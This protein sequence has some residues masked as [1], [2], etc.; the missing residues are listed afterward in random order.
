MN[1]RQP[2]TRH[3]TRGARYAATGMPTHARRRVRIAYALHAAVYTLTFTRAPHATPAHARPVGAPLAPLPT[4]RSARFL[5]QLPTSVGPFTGCGRL[6]GVVCIQVC[7]VYP[8]AP[9]L[10]T[11]Q[12][13]AATRY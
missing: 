7:V 1:D 5:D 13:A 6:Y 4:C 8:R 11:A 12:H 10:P 9:V 2:L 3:T